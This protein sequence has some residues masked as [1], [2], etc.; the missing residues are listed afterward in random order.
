MSQEERWGTRDESYSGWHRRNSIRRFVGIEKAQTLALID[1][2]AC[3]YVEYDD[4]GKEP[5][6]L[7]ETARDGGPK[8]ST[9]TRN[10]ARRASL[11][12]FVVRYIHS[13]AEFLAPGV[14]DITSFRVKQIWP[15][16]TGYQTMTPHQ[17]ANW[18]AV[19]REKCSYSADLS[20]SAVIR[21]QN[22][23]FIFE[24]SANGSTNRHA[25]PKRLNGGSLSNSHGHTNGYGDRT[26]P[27]NDSMGMRHWFKE[28][29]IEMNNDEMFWR[30]CGRNG[31]GDFK[32]LASASDHACVTAYRE[33]L[34][35]Y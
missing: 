33:L 4:R 34:R 27:W 28:R 22:S 31:I 29:Q 7:I 8:V 16:Q 20:D 13:A 10:L 2:D 1:V 14:P 21:P 24:Q 17:Y 26:L 9:V 32:D 18:L 25:N 19:Q 30:I 12:A 11:P 35:G 3:V 6:M 23:L 15:D 5:L